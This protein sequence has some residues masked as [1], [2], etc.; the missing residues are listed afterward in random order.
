M[1]STKGSPFSFCFKK[2]QKKKE[3]KRRKKEKNAHKHTNSYSL[4]Q[5]QSSWGP[6]TGCCCCCLLACLP[7]RIVSVHHPFPVTRISYRMCEKNAN[8]AQIWL[9]F[10]DGFLC[11]ACRILKLTRPVPNSIVLERGNSIDVIDTT[12]C[13]AHIERELYVKKV[14]PVMCGIDACRMGILV[15]KK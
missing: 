3:K 5:T 14:K 9:F 13:T 12:V 6:D 2:K 8:R 7:S 10:L 1:E 15:K 4:Y 11:V